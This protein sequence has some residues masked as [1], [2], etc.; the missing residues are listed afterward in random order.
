[1]RGQQNGSVALVALHHL[2]QG[3]PRCWVQPLHCWGDTHSTSFTILHNFVSSSNLT[4]KGKV[5]CAIAALHTHTSSSSA[6]P[7]QTAPQHTHGPLTVLGSSRYTTR[8]SL[9]KLIATLNH[10]LLCF[11]YP[12]YYLQALNAQLLHC[13]LTP[14]PVAASSSTRP[15]RKA[16]HNTRALT[17]LGSS[18]YTTRGSPKKLIATLSR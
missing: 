13:I 6:R 3:A 1:V 10:I 5:E 15:S 12:H 7:C 2:P 16:P 9:N 17:V 8:G 14:P 11:S 18:R 4:T